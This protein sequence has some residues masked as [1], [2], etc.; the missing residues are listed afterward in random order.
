MTSPSLPA[1]EPAESTAPLLRIPRPLAPAKITMSESETPFKEFAGGLWYEWWYG[2]TM[3]VFTLGWSYRMEGRKNIPREG[4]IL[5]IA[6]HESFIDPLLVGLAS[7]RHVWFLA[8]KTAFNGILKWFLPSVNT[9]PVDQE[10]V[11]KSGLQ[12]MVALLKAGKPVVVF[13]EGERS[14]NG[15][16]KAFKPGILLLIRKTWPTIIPVGVAGAHEALPRGQKIPIPT[17]SPLFLPPRK[18]TLAA[19]VGKP[20]DSRKYQGME[21]EAILQDLFNHVQEVQLRAEK[22]RR[23]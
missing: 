12:S 10:G 21:K 7:P 16:M 14:W 18:S 15:T 8:R 22:L 4:P 3:A 1:I 9:I 20:I 23:K 11:A 17:P 6:N 19:S 5:F 13:P 2:A